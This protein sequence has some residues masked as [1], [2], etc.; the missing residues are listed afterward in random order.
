[1]AL[2]SKK[3][4]KLP[5][6]ISSKLSFR[7][8]ALKPLWGVLLEARGPPELRNV[9]HGLEPISQMV[10][11]E[12]CELRDSCQGG[13]PGH[14][15]SPVNSEDKQPRPLHL[16]LHLLWAGPGDAVAEAQGCGHKAKMTPGESTG[17]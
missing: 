5:K 9:C 17:G 1:M 12:G 10:P 3:K 16:E 15:G 7:Q 8:S 14:I 6:H 2:K 13:S 11:C 4:K